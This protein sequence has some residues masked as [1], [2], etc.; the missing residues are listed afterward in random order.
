MHGFVFLKARHYSKMRM[1]AGK[2]Q[3]RW[4]V[5]LN[6]GR[7]CYIPEGRHGGLGAAQELNEGEA[8]ESARHELLAGAAAWL[9]VEVARTSP[10]EFVISQASCHSSIATSLLCQH[11]RIHTN[12]HE[13][14]QGNMAAQPDGAE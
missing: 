1:A 3:R 13:V 2:W 14:A 9:R 4:L 8:G 11:T 5:L 10:T 7:L 6:D 12:F